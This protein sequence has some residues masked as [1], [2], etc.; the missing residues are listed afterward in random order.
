[1][2]GI[3]LTISG[4]QK[5]WETYQGE[6]KHLRTRRLQH[7]RLENLF[8]VVR[9]Q[10]CQRDH[11]DTSQFREACRQV[12]I[13]GLL[14]TPDT[15]NC[16]P[17]EASVGSGVDRRS[18]V[19]ASPQGSEANIIKKKDKLLGR[20]IPYLTCKIRNKDTQYVVLKKHDI[21]GIFIPY[22]TRQIWNKTT[23]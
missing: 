2:L 8:G 3:Q 17:D 1:M 19:S 15:A 11:P 16:E 4:V 5:M 18:H 14:S 20:F 21:L 22:F 23:Q 6:L 7:D 12:C 13:N 10:G 9:Q